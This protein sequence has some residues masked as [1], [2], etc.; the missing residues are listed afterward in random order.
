MSNNDGVNEPQYTDEKSRTQLKPKINPENSR[1]ISM[2]SFPTKSLTC[3]QMLST[4]LYPS[5]F[6]NSDLKLPISPSLH[7]EIPN[8]PIHLHLHSSQL[9]INT[10]VQ[11]CPPLTNQLCLQPLL[12]QSSNLFLRN[13]I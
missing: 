12:Y 10:P 3:A 5:T 8:S 7:F 1:L 11:K 4:F 13:I 9:R 6:P 2:S